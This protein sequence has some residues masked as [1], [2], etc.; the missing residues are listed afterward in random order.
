MYMFHYLFRMKLNL[1][2]T[3]ELLSKRLIRISQFTFIYGLSS[4]FYLLSLQS[5]HILCKIMQVPFPI[6]T[7]VCFPAD[8][9]LTFLK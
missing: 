4:Y 6:L 3:G 1:S 7:S 8:A 5:V 2:L 9:Q